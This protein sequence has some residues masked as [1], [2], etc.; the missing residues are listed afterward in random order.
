MDRAVALDVLG[1]AQD[2]KLARDAG[3]LRRAYLRAIKKH[4]PE[5][6][7]EGF[8]RVRDAYEL[9]SRA[10][11]DNHEIELDVAPQPTLP[12]GGNHVGRQ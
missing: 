7:P 9:L 4:K 5:R 3:Q 12:R 11:F 10:S 8:R 6:D 1:L 2:P